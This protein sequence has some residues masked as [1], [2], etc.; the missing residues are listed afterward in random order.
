MK[1]RHIATKKEV[2]LTEAL[3]KYNFKGSGQKNLSQKVDQIVYVAANP[4]R[5]K[6]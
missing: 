3:E 5:K 4:Y 6:G 1:K 2:S